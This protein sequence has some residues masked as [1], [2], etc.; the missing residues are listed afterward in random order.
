ML[1]TSA[2]ADAIADA[3]SLKAMQS[4]KGT[5]RQREAIAKKARLVALACNVRAHRMR[6]NQEL[7]AASPTAQG[8]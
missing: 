2:N 6:M 5:K 4:P 7:S 3:A 1:S 8:R